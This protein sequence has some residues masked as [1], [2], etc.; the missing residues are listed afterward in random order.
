MN[1]RTTRKRIQ[2]IEDLLHQLET[3]GD[4]RTRTGAIELI[5]AVMEL[6]GDCL[7][8]IVTVLNDGGIPG[9]EILSQLAAEESISGL[10]LLYGLHPASPEERVRHALEE[11]EPLLRAQHANIEIVSID[12]QMVRIR[13]AVNGGGC[14][15]NAGELKQ[16]IEDTIIGAAPD[17]TTL[18]VEQVAL[19]PQPVFVLLHGLSKRKPANDA[20]QVAAV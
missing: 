9:R 16:L 20:P 11:L 3:I 15:S 19:E 18:T 1:D 17:I 8:R 10:L 6:H 2:R 5:Q 7:G 13:L 12:Q 4:P 14:H